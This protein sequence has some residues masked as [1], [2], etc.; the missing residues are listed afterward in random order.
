MSM[1]N[2][3]AEMLQYCAEHGIVFEAYAAMRGCP[4]SDTEVQSIAAT[5]GVGV[6]QVLGV[7][8]I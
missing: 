5:R 4:F 7:Y 6:S 2:Q 1:A 8:Y 3:E